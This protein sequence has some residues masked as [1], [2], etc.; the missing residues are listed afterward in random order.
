MGTIGAID[1]KP[2]REPSDE[3]RAR[4]RW[5]G[6]LARVFAMPPDAA[7]L[8]D[9]AR[10]AA[11]DGD[12]PTPLGRA[13][14]ALGRA[15]ARAH[16]DAVAAEHDRL[17]VGVGRAPV[18]IHASWYLSGFLHE[19]PLADLREALANFGIARREHDARTEDH[20][21]SLCEA[22]ALLAES[23]DAG[24]PAHERELFER[25]LSPWYARFAQAVD[26]SGEADWYRSAAA[27]LAT[28]LDVERQAFD[29]DS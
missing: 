19:R 13:W 1:V 21:A 8:A 15:S 28:F 9:L 23:D 25:F 7:L 18:A 20:L 6:F 12:D 26:A 27:L 14:S 16:A 22:M 17:F 4:A 10:A 24:A 11:A 29:F 5:Y 2:V 3:D